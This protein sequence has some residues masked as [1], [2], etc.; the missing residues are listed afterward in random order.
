MADLRDDF[1]HQFDAD[2][3]PDAAAADCIREHA[4][5]LHTYAAWM[6]REIEAIRG[7]GNR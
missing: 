2:G 4:G 7:E 3:K 5:E 6:D 1:E